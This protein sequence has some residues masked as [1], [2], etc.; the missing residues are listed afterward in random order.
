MTP[1]I[2]RK[3][4]KMQNKEIRQQV[5]EKIITTLK[6]GT[7]PWARPWSEFQNTG[8]PS[9]FA[10]KRQYR[11]I[12]HI[13][14]LMAGFNSCYWGTLKSWQD[15]FPEIYV[16]ATSPPTPVIFFKL[17]DGR[18]VAGKE[19]KIPLW[20]LYNV[21]NVEQLRPTEEAWLA[22]RPRAELLSIA[23]S[24]KICVYQHTRQ[25]IAHNI[26]DTASQW[27]GRFKATGV[28]LNTQPDFAPAE[29][30][31]VATG[32][33]IKIGGSR[34]CYNPTLDQVRLPNKRH[35]NTMGD[36]YE[37]AF[38]EI[39]HWSE[40]RLARAGRKKEHSYAF[41]E[42]VAEISA[43]FLCAEINV[44]HADKMLDKSASYV[45]AWLKQMG[46]NP[47]FVFDAAAQAS[48][49]VDYILSLKHRQKRKKHVA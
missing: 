32:A 16:P 33:D 31:L 20:R 26:H 28:I 48:K 9:N 37:T 24:H 29:R 21:Y 45:D 25:Q 6:D 2:G 44:P 18:M 39:A 22:N 8:I 19:V 46:D 34:A 14:L 13:L 17:L 40:S 1:T 41:N 49:V 15:R 38:H 36:Y 11:G 4:N 10:S 27:L 7:R 30:L 5:T 3:G 47:K 23:K 35:F 43:C 42:L 12:N